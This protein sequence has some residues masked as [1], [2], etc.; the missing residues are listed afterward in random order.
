MAVNITANPTSSNPGPRPANQK[1]IYTIYDSAAVPDR[2]VVFVY[3]SSQVGTGVIGSEIAKLYLTPNSNDRVH[4]DLSDIAVG[5]VNAPTETDSGDL[6]HSTTLGVDA[7][8]AGA[9]MKYTVKCGTY[10]AG[11]ESAPVDPYHVYLHGGGIQLREGL[12]PS[13]ANFYPTGVTRDWFLTD[14]A[15]SAVNPPTLQH[16]A[17]IFMADED[18]AGIFAYTTIFLDVPTTLYQIRI[19]LYDDTGALVH[20]ELTVV[21]Y[22]GFP[23]IQGFFW[24]M[25]LGPANVATLLGANWDTD[26]AYYDIDGVSSGA[27]PASQTKTIRVRRDCRPIKNDPVQ[28]AWA[29]SVGGWDYLRFDGRNLQQ[30]DTETKTFRK[31]IGSY[32]AAAFSFNPWDREKAAYHVTGNEK[33]QLRNKNFNAQERDLLQYAFR[34]NNVHYRV[35]TGDWLPCMIDTGSYTIESASAKLFD[36]SFTITLSQDLRC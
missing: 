36:V 12:H 19:R 1:L 3:E 22:P 13:F 35:G 5:R 26:W 7:V 4:F 10:T 24:V 21:S 9:I 8:A 16:V 32:D 25:P 6:V 11:V 30:V 14:L 18:E 27:R 29:N 2:Y 28:L 20:T 34:S 23:E 33:Y 31:T 15:T 17:E